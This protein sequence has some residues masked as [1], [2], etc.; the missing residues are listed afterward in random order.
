MANGQGEDVV[1]GIADKAECPHTQ[2]LRRFEV[3]SN[4]ASTPTQ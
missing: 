2:L 1:N 3:D 4:M